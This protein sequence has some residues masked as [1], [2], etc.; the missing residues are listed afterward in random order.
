MTG[1][2]IRHA[3]A[4]HEP[5][6]TDA[7]AAAYLRALGLERRDPDRAFL[8]DIVRA[9]LERVPFEN[10]SK[11]YRLATAGLRDVPAFDVHLDGIVR[12]HAGG[13]CYAN[14]FH[15]WRLLLSLGFAARLCAAD[16]R[17][18]DVHA[19]IVVGVDGAGLLV[20]AGY[21]APFVRPMP[22]DGPG[23][24]V[25]RN[26]R[27]RYIVRPRDAAGRTRL[28]LFRNGVL[29]HGYTLKP[30]ARV[31]GDFAAAVADSFRPDATFM[32]AVLVTRATRTGSTAICNLTVLRSS[33]DATR[34]ERLAGRDALIDAIRA[35]FGIPAEITR[36][37]IS[38]VQLS[39]DPYA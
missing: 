33:P 23:D 31:P 12:L 39:A 26:G 29:R 16:M 4:G 25:V 38:G 1:P 20:D 13:T 30:A 27:D 24:V 3:A 18:P 37:A 14:N 35:G 10:V 5:A 36:R 17:S 28:D 6:L 34:T 32:N 9:Q 15:L 8:D 7:E 11:L 21:G 19:A 22:L 2:G